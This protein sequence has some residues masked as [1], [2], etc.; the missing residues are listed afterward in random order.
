L[1]DRLSIDTPENILLDADI[2]GF[3]TRCIAAIL[4]YLLLLVAMI[5]IGL[6]YLQSVPI[7]DRD[8][9]GTLAIVVLLQFVLIAFYHLFFEFIWNGQTPGKRWVGIRVV[10]VNGLPITVSGVLIRN[11]VRLFDFMPFFY[12]IGLLV[13]F[14]SKHTQRLGDLAAHTIV[15]RERRALTLNTVK[16]DLKVSY[17][18]LTP[19]DPIPAHV[20]IDNLTPDDRRAIIDFLRRRYT[21]TQREQLARMLAERMYAKMNTGLNSFYFYTGRQAET[22]LE[23]IARAF[24]IR[25]KVG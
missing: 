24:E 25:E 16:E 4:D 9:T 7:R 20:Q 6:L 18:Y 21:L 12:A 11:L 17:H 1:D 3:G 2:A 10:Q 8:E 22:L 19:I 14:A 23:Q 15:I 13:M 5:I